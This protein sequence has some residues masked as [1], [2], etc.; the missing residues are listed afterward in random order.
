MFDLHNGTRS[1]LCT[2]DNMKQMIMNVLG[3]ND[4]GSN[5]SSTPDPRKED[6]LVQG[7]ML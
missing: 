4:E 2:T 7:P 3:I 1:L 5:P 6:N